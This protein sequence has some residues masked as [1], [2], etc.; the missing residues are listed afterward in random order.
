[1][2]AV[3]RKQRRAIAIAAHEPEKLYKRNRGLKDMTREQMHEFAKTSEKRL[4]AKKRSR[5]AR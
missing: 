4:P 1:M 2:P 5:K 3:S